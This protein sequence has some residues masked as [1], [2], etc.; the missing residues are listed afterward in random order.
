MITKENFSNVL[1]CLGFEKEGEVFK[2]DFPNLGTCT[3]SADFKNK[4][5]NYPE[6]L[7]FTI[8]DRTTCNFEHPENFVVLDACIGCLKRVIALNI[9]NLKSVGISDTIPKA[10]RLISAFI[11]KTSRK[12]CLSLSVKQQVASMLKH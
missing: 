1:E 6:N 2:K 12:C 9:S 3:M 11:I 8:N 7:G 5:L 4:Q 10:V